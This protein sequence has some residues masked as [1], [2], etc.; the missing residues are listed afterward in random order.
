MYGRATESY[1]TYSNTSVEYQF[2]V[3]RILSFSFCV[4]HLPVQ[5]EHYHNHGFQVLKK[6]STKIKRCLFVFK[7]F[8][9][10]FHLVIFLAASWHTESSGQGSHPSHSFNLQSSCSKARSFNPLCQAGDQTCAAEMSLISLCHNG[11]SAILL[12]SI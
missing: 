5:T 12:F 6:S 4:C 3:S 7:I 9:I 11:N 8:E 2:E 10:I 1:A